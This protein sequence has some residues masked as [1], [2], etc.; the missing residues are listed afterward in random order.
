MATDIQKAI[1]EADAA[2]PCRRKYKCSGYDDHMCSGPYDT[3][4]KCEEP[5]TES[6]RKCDWSG[7]AA[8]RKV[9]RVAQEGMRERAASV[10]EI[11]GDAENYRVLASDAIAAIRALAIEEVESD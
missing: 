1:A 7:H 2:C 10:Y 6:A 5:E 8:I 9:A 11:Q 3:P 4:C